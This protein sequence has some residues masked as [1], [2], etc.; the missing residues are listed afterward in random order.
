MFAVE[1]KAGK[2]VVLVNLEKAVTVNPYPNNKAQTTISF[3]G[4]EYNYVIV[5]EPYE[6]VKDLMMAISINL[7]A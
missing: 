4:S 6:K 7:N 5:D 2:S 3:E 1:F